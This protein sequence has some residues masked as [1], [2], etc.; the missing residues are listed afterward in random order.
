MDSA[1]EVVSIACSSKE[2]SPK[3][4]DEAWFESRR[5]E[6]CSEYTLFWKLEDI[7]KWI[8]GYYQKCSFPRNTV[9]RDLVQLLFPLC[10]FQ[11]LL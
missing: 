9:A 10:L 6:M 1:Y 2:I 5:K 4:T 8:N 11:I 7:C 3:H